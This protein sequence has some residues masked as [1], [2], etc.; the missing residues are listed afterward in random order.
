MRQ[1]PSVGN[2]VPRP[3]PRPLALWPLYSLVAAAAVLGIS[4]HLNIDVQALLWGAEDMAEY[5]SRFGTPEFSDFTHIAKLMAETL[6]IAVW[7]TAIAV[8]LQ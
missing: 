6:A 1:A 3:P 4:R 2:H 5:L 8:F 7:G